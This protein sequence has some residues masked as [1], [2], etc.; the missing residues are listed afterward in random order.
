MAYI[1]K[2]NRNGHTYYYLQESARVNGKPKTI[3]S[4]YLGTAETIGNLA[5]IAKNIDVVAPSNSTPYEFASV[6][7]L[8]D[9]AERNGIREIIDKHAGKRA[10]GLPISDY[11]VL[12]AINRVV[13]ATSKVGFYDWFKTTT[14]PKSFPQANRKN[15]SS[16]GF[17]NNMMILDA[18]KIEAIEDEITEKIVK[19]YNLPMDCLLFDNTNFFT[20][21]NT[22]N[23][24]K[25]PQRGHS[26]ENRK[27]LKI[28]G[29]S[30]MASPCHNIPLFHATYPGN[31]NDAKQFAAIVDNLKNRYTKINP[32]CSDVTL[33]FDKGN[34]SEENI[35][36]LALEEPTRFHFVGGLRLNQCPELL[37]TPKSK[38]KLLEGDSFGQ[39]KAFRSKK[40]VYGNEFTVVI[41]DNPS[42]YDAQL[43]GVDKNIK[44]CLEEFKD[45]ENKLKLRA[46]GFVTKGRDY[47]VESVD[48]RIKSILS[49]EHMKTV[50]EYQIIKGDGSSINIKFS[51]NK[52]KLNELKKQKLGKTILFTDRH[53]WPTERI[54][55]AYRAQYHVEECFRQMKDTKVL[56]FRPIRHYTDNNIMVH[57]FYCVLALTLSSLMNLELERLGNK[58]SIKKMVQDFSKV[59]QSLVRFNS[60]NKKIMKAA[61]PENIPAYV[62]K[63]IKKFNLKQYALKI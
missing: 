48:K 60:Q 11:M 30:L 63:Y 62:E 51:L 47:T 49:G 40:E 41:T 55:G 34:N 54:V 26:K 52:D 22:T 18:G 9:I 42:L 10:Q 17:W 61:Y 27:D 58:T 24:A 19:N 59:T 6:S 31:T 37:S 1:V 45:L 13:D 15:L 2:R 12:A 43:R 16:Q 32:D 7:A 57:A 28:V 20:Y 8:L 56:S 53:D 4:K 21:I 23:K 39:A 36:K 29:L 46:T 14:L 35:G 38:Y 44:K 50:F 5:D 33:V 25:I 3:L